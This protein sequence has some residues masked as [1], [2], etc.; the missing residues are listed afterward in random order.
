[1]VKKK[2]FQ[3]LKTESTNLMRCS[4]NS[5]A[6]SRK[7]GKK[8]KTQ[9]NLLNLLCAFAPLRL[10]VIV[11]LCFFTLQLKAQ[12]Q[13]ININNDWKFFTSEKIN[14]AVFTGQSFW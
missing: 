7:A 8:N 1:M 11:M 2:I 14:T 12:R 4:K 3:Q 9:R 10:Y 5:E 13:D 6:F